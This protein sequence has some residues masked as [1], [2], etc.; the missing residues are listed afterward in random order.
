LL[1]EE[2]VARL[3]ALD[4]TIIAWTVNDPAIART[5]FELG[6][7][8]FTSDNQEMLAAIA[9]RRERAFDQNPAADLPEEPQ[10][11]DHQ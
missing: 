1:A 6:V 10:G 3:H 2:T 8:G 4:T 7:D 5:L 11:L 9:Q